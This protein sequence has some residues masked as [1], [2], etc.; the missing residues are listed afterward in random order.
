MKQWKI[1]LA[2]GALAL[3][4]V[5]VSWLFLSRAGLSM[6]EGSGVLLLET[7]AHALA[8]LLAAP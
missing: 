5:T 2:T 4:A 3:L 1:P 7:E 8:R 6:G